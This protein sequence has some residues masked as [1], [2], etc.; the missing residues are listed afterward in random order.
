MKKQF[1]VVGINVFLER[2]KTR[3]YVGCLKKEKKQ[4]VFTYDEKYFRTK[5]IISLG[6]EFPLTKKQFFSKVLFPSFDD[7][8][9]S[10][11][12]PAYP[13]YC[14]ATGIN[15]NEKDPFILLSTIGQ[16]GPSSFIFSPIYKRFFTEKD[17]IKF[18]HSLGITTREF[19]QIFE[20]SQSSLNS[21]E[22]KKS[23]G[24]DFLKKLEILLRFPEVALYFLK[25][26]G[27]VLQAKKR[28]NAEKVL[29]QLHH[30]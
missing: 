2:R 28:E 1:F 26:N 7:R 10:K 25:I 29:H 18:R 30:T 13:E 8:I 12:N 9:P 17:V 20:V 23:V 14:L 6:P 3:M 27:G 11:E 21:F 16:R 22:R 5:N 24:K 15:P 19:A 4:F